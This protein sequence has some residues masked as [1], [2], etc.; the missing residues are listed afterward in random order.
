MSR[1]RQREIHARR[2]RKAKLAK[3][4]TQYASATGVAREGILAKVR[5]VSPA[6]TEDQF[7]SSAKKK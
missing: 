7:V 4:R 2:K 1:I 6:M 5:R 3:L